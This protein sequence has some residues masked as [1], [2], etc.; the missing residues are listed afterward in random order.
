MF[1]GP[2]VQVNTV[3]GDALRPNAN[4]RDVWADVAVEAI[5]VHAKVSRCIAK[6]DKPWC[7]RRRC[8]RT[9]HMAS[10]CDRAEF[11]TDAGDAKRP[12]GPFVSGWRADILTLSPYAKCL[13]VERHRTGSK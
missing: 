3:K 1:V 9:S 8:C 7:N 2:G 5:F 4:Y 13:R 6:P 10:G 11:P 12:D